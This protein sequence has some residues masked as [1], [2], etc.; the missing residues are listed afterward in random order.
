[1]SINIMSENHQ[2]SKEEIALE[3]FVYLTSGNVK[4]GVKY[5]KVNGFTS[6]FSSKDIHERQY[7]AEEYLV[8]FEK[9][10]AV[11]KYKNNE[12]NIGLKLII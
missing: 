9:C 5:E 2:K 3:L 6:P 11:V 4:D 12:E 10:I 7:R 1:M 8:F